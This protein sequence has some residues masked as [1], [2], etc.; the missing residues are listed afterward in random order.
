MVKI[1]I[2]MAVPGMLSTGEFPADGVM[3]LIT[4]WKAG[5]FFSITSPNGNILHFNP[6]HV[7]MIEVLG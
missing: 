5:E 4:A 2:I 3:G 1:R 7:A 6:A